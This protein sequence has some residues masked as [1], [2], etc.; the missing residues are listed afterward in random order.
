MDSPRGDLTALWSTCTQGVVLARLV[1]EGV[2]GQLGGGLICAGSRLGCAG[3]GLQWAENGLERLGVVQIGFDYGLARITPV[4]RIAE[5]RFRQGW[6]S[7]IRAQEEA[8]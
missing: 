2:L 3:G 4:G 5:S 8:S 6:S 7:F 1:R